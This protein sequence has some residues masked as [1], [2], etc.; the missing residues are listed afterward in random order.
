[1]RAT[2]ILRTLLALQDTLVSGLEFTAESLIVDV[3]P[4]WH[5]ARCGECRRKGPSEGGRTRS[6]RHLDLAGIKCVLRYRIR[7]VNCRHCGVKTEH[8]P[9]AESGSRF[10]EPFEAHTTYLAQC[11]DKT[12]VT[13]LMRIAWET[14]GKIIQRVVRRHRGEVDRL[15]GLRIIGVDEL[16]YRR[17]HK[18][19]TVVVDHETGEII[20]AAEGKSAE[21]LTQFFT[22]LGPERCAE[23]EAVTIDMSAAYIKAVTEA[24]PEATIIFDRFHVQRL[25]SKAVD[26]VRRDEVREA[27]VDDKK[28][29]KKTRWALLK[30]PWNLTDFESRKLDQLQRTNQR[31]Y[32]AYLLE[33]AL[34]AVLDC[35]YI[36]LARSKLDEWLSWA[37]RSRLR[38]FVKLARTIR[39][40]REGILE[41]VRD[42]LNNG[43]VEGLNGKARTITRRSYGFHSAASLISMLFL[44]C[45][46]IHAYPA[47]IYPFWTH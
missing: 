38:P 12:T 11:N 20:W 28:A 39:Q 21:T 1:M 33:E 7:R 26:E 37:S 36:W 10:T 4:T 25:A 32:R 29:L 40:H 22:L 43:R 18:Y 41:Y 17:H 44:C 16:S 19:V 30:N 46:G 23:L 47:H 31:I 24:S 45:G 14:V 27:E 9:W 34:A 42:R 13:R 8:V 15:D 5:R 35:R 2:S 6:W 3:K